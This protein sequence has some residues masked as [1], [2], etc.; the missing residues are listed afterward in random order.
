M[1]ARLWCGVRREGS[2]WRLDPVTIA[3]DM[4]DRHVPRERTVPNDS[5]RPGTTG[6][7]RLTYAELGARLRISAEAARILTRRRGWQRIAPNRRGA[8]AI[9]VMPAEA[10]AGEDW[11]P[12]RGTPLDET[13]TAADVRADVGEQA[14]TSERDRADAAKATGGHGRT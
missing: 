7:L 5:G 6:D 4:P 12:D 9:V 8:P 1:V 3:S 2:A 10:L 14:D 13:R 11:R